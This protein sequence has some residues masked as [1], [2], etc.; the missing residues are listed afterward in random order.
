M[1]SHEML[2]SVPA[3]NELGLA[4]FESLIWYGLFVPAATPRSI[5]EQIASDTETLLQDPGMLA[6]LRE[7]AMDAAY[8]GQADF[9]KTVQADRQ[10][11]ESSS[12]KL[13]SGR[14]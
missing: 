10:K 2:P 4:G 6:R 11:W 3:L 8:A 1:K 12:P 14:D 7:L 5:V 13:K 9:A